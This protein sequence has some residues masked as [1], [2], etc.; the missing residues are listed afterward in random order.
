MA[1]SLRT[2]MERAP[3]PDLGTEPIPKTRYTS[4]EYARREWDRMWTRVWLMAGRESD[5]TE[6]GDYFSFEIGHESDSRPAINQTRV[7]IRSHS[8]RAYSGLV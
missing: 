3:R 5:V 4:P 1:E 2:P 6:P 8:R 7:H